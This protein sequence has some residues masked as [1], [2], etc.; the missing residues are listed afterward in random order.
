MPSTSTFRY[1]NEAYRK[2]EPSLLLAMAGGGGND[3]DDINNKR[4][5][6]GGG[7]GGGGGEH[8]RDDDSNSEEYDGSD[9]DQFGFVDNRRRSNNVILGGLLSLI[10]HRGETK[11]P[12][13]ALQLASTAADSSAHRSLVAVSLTY[14]SQLSAMA[15]NHFQ[16][17]AT[18]M[19]RSSS[20]YMTKLETRPL[21]TKCI[22]GGI[23]GFL[24]DLGAQFFAH[25]LEEGCA[26]KKEGDVAGL[27]VEHKS[28]LQYDVRRGMSVLAFSMFFSGPVLH[29]SY[30]LFEW[31]L[32]VSKMPKGFRTLASSAHVLADALILDSLFVASNMLVTGVLEGYKLKDDIIPQFQTDYLGTLKASLGMSAVL[33]PYQLCCF[34]LL[35]PSLRVLA[36]NF[37]D[38]AWD[39]L[40]NYKSHMGR[41]T[42]TTEKTLNIY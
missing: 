18:A 15:K 19:S 34:R 2:N 32:P 38:V 17:A 12:Q 40:V 35:P 1:A 42:Q 37:S 16:S 33:A 20:W 14:H 31:L 22:T 9:D 10:L 5:G 4:R 26:S 36:V 28:G 24:G 6:D 39:G 11:L 7:G 29:Y 27:A 25:A 30:D 21:F 8:N 13:T 3:D 23:I 41:A